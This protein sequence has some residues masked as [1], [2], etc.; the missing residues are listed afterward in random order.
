MNS[1]LEQ[2]LEWIYP[3]DAC[4]QDAKSTVH[5][6]P[7]VVEP[8]SLEQRIYPILS[9]GHGPTTRGKRSPVYKGFQ[10]IEYEFNI[11]VIEIVRR[12]LEDNDW[13]YTIVND[14]LPTNH[15]N[16][17]SQRVD[18]INKINTLGLFPLIVD[19]HANAYGSN[20]N[21]VRGCETWVIESNNADRLT[22]AGIFQSEM[23]KAH[24]NPDRGIKMDR[25]IPFTMLYKTPYFAFILEAGFMTNLEEAK[26][27]AGQ[28]IFNQANAVINSLQK[29]NTWVS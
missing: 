17:L 21:S 11:A 15:G 19:Q 4:N 5:V 23:V 2:F 24:N 20:W 29:I 7:I 28:G 6:E 26:Y 22:I 25:D 12:W 14:Y 18:V 27:L 16:N 9:A 1:L 13:E 3:Q 8:E 10:L